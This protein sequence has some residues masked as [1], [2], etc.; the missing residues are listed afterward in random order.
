MLF[1]YMLYVTLRDR[2]LIKGAGS[3][4]AVVANRLSET[5]DF[6]VLLLEAGGDETGITDTPAFAFNF[7][8]TEKDWNYTID[9]DSKFCLSEID[10]KCLYPRGKILGGSSAVNGMVTS[11]EINEL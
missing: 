6:Q 4:G 1:L 3:A 2:R 9:S 10:K 7:F 5:P 8:G 11:E